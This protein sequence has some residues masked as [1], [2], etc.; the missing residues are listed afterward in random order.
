MMGKGFCVYVDSMC[1][2]VHT[3]VQQQ[4]AKFTISCLENYLLVVGINLHRII[5]A[6][7]LSTYLSIYLAA[8]TCKPGTMPVGNLLAGR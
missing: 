2:A 7:Y 3:Y 8:F 6:T 4:G 5:V 1:S